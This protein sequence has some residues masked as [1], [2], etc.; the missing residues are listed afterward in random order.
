MRQKNEYSPLFKLSCQFLKYFLF[1]FAGFAIACILSAVFSSLETA[2]A[3]WLSLNPWFFKSAVVVV[4]L[5]ATTAIY[6]SFHRAD[7][8]R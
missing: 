4:C 2:S 6:E 5:L 8:N 7:T 1:S 3:L